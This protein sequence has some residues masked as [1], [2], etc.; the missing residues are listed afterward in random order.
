VSW[1]IVVSS[2]SKK[3]ICMCS[4]KVASSTVGYMGKEPQGYIKKLR[5]RESA[6]AAPQSNAQKKEKTKTAIPT[7]KPR[8]FASENGARDVGESV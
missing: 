4:G 7:P 2:G 1:K 3:K 5:G 8:K 6:S